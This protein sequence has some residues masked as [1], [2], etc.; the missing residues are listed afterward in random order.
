MGRWLTISPTWNL[1]EA[2][3]HSMSGDRA[4]PADSLGRSGTEVLGGGGEPR[5]LLL[6]RGGE[7]GGPA[8]VGKLPREVQPF[9]DHRIKGLPN[10][11]GDVFANPVGHVGRAEKAD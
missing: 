10:V 4:G 2:I 9:L 8:E 11:R 6:D 7:L 3:A 1:C 5:A